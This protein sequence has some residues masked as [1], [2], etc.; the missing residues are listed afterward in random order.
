MSYNTKMF[1][2]CVKAVEAGMPVAQRINCRSVSKLQAMRE[3]V[4]E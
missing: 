1:R 2:V 3:A 4:R